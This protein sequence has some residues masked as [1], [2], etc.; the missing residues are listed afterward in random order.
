MSNPDPAL[1]P[2]ATFPAAGDDPF[3][4]FLFLA[5]VV[6]HGVLVIRSHNFW[7]GTGQGRGSGAVIKV[8][9]AALMLA[10]PFAFITEPD[11]T[12]VVIYAYVCWFTFLYFMALTVWRFTAPK[13]A[14]LESNHTRTI[15]V[16]RE[17]GYR[18]IGRGSRAWL[19]RLPGNQAF[20][21]DLTEKTLRLRRLPTA[22][23]GLSILHLSDVHFI[24]TPDRDYYRHIF[25]LCAA[26]EPDLVA[27]T[28]DTVDTDVHHRWIVPLFG[29]LKWR[30]GAFGILGN[31]DYYFEPPLLRRRLWRA[32]VRVIGNGW[33]RIE[34]RGEPLVLVGQ[35][36]PWFRPAPDLLSCPAEPFRLCLSHTPDNIAWA[37]RN[38]IDLMLAGHVHGG[39]IRLPGI[40]SVLVPSQ[41]GR[42]YDCGTFEEPPTVLHVSRGLS[43]EHPLRYGCRPEVTKLILR[44]AAHRAGTA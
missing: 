34:V 27:F 21:V 2:F 26:W 20:Q 3:S 19:T 8:S 44:P 25:D 5:A 29:R 12:L 6:G 38:R 39:Q 15:D 31:H 35:E 33:L 7:Y 16:A 9:H 14:V 41:Y 1:V 11:S 28:G 43:G 23:D 10:G 32:G 18:P 13:P 22:W 40:G 37:R 4:V 36:G 42:R 17:L 24:G 30:C